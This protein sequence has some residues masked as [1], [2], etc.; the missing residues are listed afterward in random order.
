MIMCSSS[1]KRTMCTISMPPSALEREVRVRSLAVQSR[2]GG[3]PREATTVD[4][5]DNAQGASAW[6]PEN[7]DQSGVY[8][9][10]L[11]SCTRTRTMV[12]TGARRLSDSQSSVANVPCVSHE[13][14][15]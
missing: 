4:T 3:V 9:C 7:R 8:S 11:Y 1:S 10:I 13:Y 15:R 2:T 6:L 14:G 5:I 12:I